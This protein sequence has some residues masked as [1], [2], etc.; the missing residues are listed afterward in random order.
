MRSSEEAV[1]RGPTNPE[2]K[3]TV[4]EALR[5]PWLSYRPKPLGELM[6][7]GY[8]D[9]SRLEWAASNAYNPRLKQAAQVLLHTKA[10]VLARESS[11][12]G[13]K[14]SIPSWNQLGVSLREAE[15]TKWPFGTLKGETMGPLVRSRRLSLKDLAYA[16]ENAWDDRLRQA[17]IALS[18]VRLDQAIEE[19][20]SA[21][22]PL[23][24]VKGDERSFAQRRQ[25]QLATWQ[26][27]IGG[28]VIGILLMLFVNLVRSSG[29]TATSHLTIREVVQTPAGVIAVA[30]V[31]LG[32]LGIYFGLSLS[33]NWAW[34]GLE[35]KS[36]VYRKGEAGE[37]AVVEKARRA[38]DGNWTLFRNIALP[39][40]SADLD[41][42]LV[43]PPG[44]WAIEVKS[45]SGR[46]KNIG[47][48]WEYWA[49]GG[50]KR[51]HKSPSR[52]A[53]NGALA[54]KDFLAADGIRTFISAAIAWA[55]QEGRL[56]VENPTVPVWTMERLDDELG[57]LWSGKHLDAPTIERIVAKLSKLYPKAAA[58]DSW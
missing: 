25:L 1:P 3:M 15:A 45:L 16:I 24:V 19:I 46:Y 55:N 18:L 57:N 4:A 22:G 40:K 9:R 37:D 36:E 48:G 10:D 26:G 43:G 35:R 8:L 32:A 13:S 42:V 30:L 2:P 5:V 49:K 34:D 47:E 38:L 21:A 7:E 14:P 23:N 41:I 29:R 44:V 51:W 58:T 12:M 52:Q 39:G 11:E 33:F 17:A 56:S 50:W 53:R 6:E 27:A 20:P 28:G 54:L 31:L